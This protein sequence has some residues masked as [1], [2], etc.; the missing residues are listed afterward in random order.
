MKKDLKKT[1]LWCAFLFIFWILPCFSMTVFFKT[2]IY[3]AFFVLSMAVLYL[4]KKETAALLG[5][6]AISLAAAIYEYEYLFLVL[7]VVLLIY[8]HRS[9]TQSLTSKGESK[10]AGGLTDTYT[11]LSF[12][13]MIGQLVYSFIVYQTTEP[14]RAEN[15]LYALEVAPLFI[16]LFI[17]LIVQTRSKKGTKGHK[18][19]SKKQSSLKMIYFVSLFGT[20][21]SVSTFYAVNDYGT[22]HNRTEYVF[23]FIFV[24]LMAVNKD[25]YICSGIEKI[26]KRLSN[27]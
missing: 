22:Q 11:T 7:P 15:I 20:V 19:D 24:M 8:A 23:W 10:S 13:L 12:I 5:L 27:L 18:A 4:A 16:A 14:H 17:F 1:F 6:S 9:A 26:E 2:Y 25:P 3:F 21:I